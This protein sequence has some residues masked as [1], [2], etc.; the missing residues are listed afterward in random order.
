MKKIVF[1]FALML[2]AITTTEQAQACT[3][4]G[5]EKY[6]LI[7]EVETLVQQISFLNEEYDAMK[8]SV[9]AEDLATFQAYLQHKKQELIDLAVKK[10]QSI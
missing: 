5:T 4:H 2:A 7:D 1:V 9:S 3:L 8:A 6:V 10:V